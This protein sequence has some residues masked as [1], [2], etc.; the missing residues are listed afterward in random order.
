MGRR[1]IPRPKYSRI[2][3]DRRPEDQRE[4]SVP[5]PHEPQ[6]Y[7]KLRV[8]T[9]SKPGPKQVP[10]R[11]DERHRTAGPRWVPSGT[12]SP[13]PAPQRPEPPKAAGGVLRPPSV[14]SGCLGTAGSPASAS[15][16][17]PPTA[18]AASNRCP[19]FLITGWY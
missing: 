15:A 3:K 10:H 2:N 5:P 14:G 11:S 6:R 9:L 8:P 1:L 18:I 17:A 19:R 7:A 16:F 12:Y 13:E 4:G